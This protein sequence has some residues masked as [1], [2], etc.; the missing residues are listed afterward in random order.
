MRPMRWN[1]LGL[2]FNAAD[3]SEWM[4]GYAMLPCVRPLGDGD[5]RVYFSPRDRLNRSRPASLDFNIADPHHIFNLSQRPLLELGPQGAYDESGVMPTCLAEIDGRWHMFFNGWSLGKTVPFYS[6][7]G[8]ARE[9]EG[10]VFERLARHPNALDR[11][12]SDPY[13]TFAPFVL[14]DGGIWRMWYVSL[15]KWEGASRHYYHIKYAESP[16]GLA[17][18]PRDIVC[19]DFSSPTEFALGRPMVVR[20]PDRYRMWFCSRALHGIE[21][22]RIRYAESDDGIHWSRL[23]ELAGI[24]VSQQGW[25]SGMIC[26]PFVFDHGGQRFM[27]YNG[28][29]YGRTGFGLAVLESD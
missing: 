3:N 25:D 29:D 22:Y 26:Y 28:N 19:L 10:G 15:V 11:S 1:K 4:C 6:F 8:I 21:A 5:F 27:L 16:D 13:S 12:A 9:A 24:D 20:D 23:D 14:H 17:W 2:M 7:N 18:A